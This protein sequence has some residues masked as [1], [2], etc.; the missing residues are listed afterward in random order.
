M[1]R[2][3]Y[4]SQEAL[5]LHGAAIYRRDGRNVCATEVAPVGRGP[6]SCWPDLK[7]IGQVEQD[8]FLYVVYGSR[9]IREEELDAYADADDGEPYYDDTVD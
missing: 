9:S 8:A 3:I 2:D 6:S 5:E 7:F 1:L 4:F